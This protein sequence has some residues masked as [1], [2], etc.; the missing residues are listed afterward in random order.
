MGFALIYLTPAFFTDTTQGVVRCPPWE[1]ILI[2][3]AGVWSE[4]YLCTISTVVWWGTPPGTAIHDFAY[5]LVLMTGIATGVISE[6][7][8]AHETGRIPHSL[9]RHRDPR[10]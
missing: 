2:S 1:R 9:R 6:L 10:A 4:L 3:V 7:E 5:I 8:S